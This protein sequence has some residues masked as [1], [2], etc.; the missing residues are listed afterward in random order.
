MEKPLIII[1]REFQEKLLQLVNEY[2]PNVPARY[3]R[4]DIED[5][6]KQLAVL[7]EQQIKEVQKK[8]EESEVNENG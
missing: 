2:I 6:S 8:L 1:E 4:F 3:L 5:V 7:E